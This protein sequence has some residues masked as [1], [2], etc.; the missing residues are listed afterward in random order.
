MSYLALFLAQIVFAAAWAGEL[1][2]SAT[3]ASIAENA[4]TLTVT[5]TRTGDASGAASVSIAS[6]D[7][8]AKASTDY[9]A[10]SST[11]NWTA[12][13]SD[14]KT[15]DV[16]IT[17]NAILADDKLFTLGLSSATG[18]TI[19]VNSSM[20]IT[21]TDYEEGILQFNG[22]TFQAAED[23]KVAR[24]K[25]VRTSGTKGAV[26]GTISFAD[27]T[28]VKG[29]DYF[30]ADT[31]VTIA[32]GDAE[33]IIEV[34]LKDDSIGE[35]T[36][37]F[38]ATLSAPTGG[39]TL[40]TQATSTVEIFDTDADF[41]TAAVK[42]AMSADKVTQ[43]D[44]VDLNQ[45]ALLNS[46]KTYVELINEIPLLATSKL[47]VSQPAGGLVEIEFGDDKFYLRPTRISRNVLGLA[48]GV[49]TQGSN[50]YRFVT[51]DGHIID[52]QPAVASVTSLQAALA[53]L[54]MPNV[55]ITDQGNITIQKDQGVP[56][57]EENANGELVLSDSF[58]DRWHI[59]AVAMVTP[60][61]YSV[62][63]I[64]Q[65]AHPSVSGQ[66]II[67]LYFQVGSEYKVQYFSSAPANDGELE[68]ALRRRLGVTEV[69]FGDYGIINFKTI[70]ATGGG[71]SS[72][73]LINIMADYSLTK[74]RDFSS[75]QQGFYDHV[76]I[77]GD[78][79]R[80]YRMVYSNGDQQVF[81]YISND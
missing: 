77:N 33:A 18:D 23:G 72:T 30:G 43:P 6:T 40:G 26:G 62:T 58:Y 17:D 24:I 25:V 9:T 20:S 38:T 42:V 44:V 31:S 75:D 66:A 71:A 15:V 54:S 79:F 47:T 67:S 22:A 2:F 60:S 46:A 34:V 8:T 7:G 21:I 4:T 41:T 39:A 51:S 64:Y 36:E 53:T 19:G 81:F 16:T 3:T 13:N 76:D 11:L 29:S 12:G 1:N 10:V 74:I 70:A 56:K 78:G 55:V 59:R 32:D 52:M 69:T 63:G 73:N 28:A 57:I 37:T 61:A 27:V 14:S 68:V 48:S 50:L 65:E 35:A 45:A 5:V 49:R 80:D